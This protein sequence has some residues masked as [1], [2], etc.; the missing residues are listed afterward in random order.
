[1]KRVMTIAA[2]LVFAVAGLF[3]NGRA[4]GGAVVDTSLSTVM[5]KGALVLGLDDSFPPLGFRNEANEIVGFDIDLAKEATRRMGIRLVLQP[6]DWNAK[7]QELNTGAIDCIWNG[8]VVTEE[9]KKV[10]TFTPPYFLQGQILIVKSNTPYQKL[11]DLAGKSIGIQYSST[12]LEAINEM[13]AF[14]SSLKEIVEYKD[15][16]TAFMDMETGG[17]EAVV[18][19]LTVAQDNIQR[20]GRNFRILGETL[21]ATAFDVGVG[22]RKGDQALADKVWEVLVAMDKDGTVAAISQKWFGVNISVI[23][24]NY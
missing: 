3:A 15:Y 1:M 24:R 18:C 13:P 20:S 12:S 16:L 22:F 21:D 11:A 10:I 4:A 5:S 19:P 8:F 2:C 6:I 9:R 14:K 17:I 23:S 7:E